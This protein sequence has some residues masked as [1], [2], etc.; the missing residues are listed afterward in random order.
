[1]ALRVANAPCSW[2]ALEFDWAGP[3]PDFARVLD[4]ISAAGYVGTELGDWGF[5]PT[6]P[7]AL[8]RE[9][10]G[11]HLSLIG[12]F[13]PVRLTVDQAHDSGVTSAVRVATL[14]AAAGDAPFVVL[15]DDTARDPVRT[16]RAGRVRP[17]DGLDEKG[18]DTLARGANRIAR[19]VKKETGLRTVFHHHC[20][21]FVETPGE[22]D[23]LMS[24]TD[25]ALVG[26]CLDTG[27]CAF[28]GGKP[29]S[30]A[31]RWKDRVWHVHLKDCE[32]ALRTQS[33]IEGWDY[34]ESVRRG[35]FCELG[36]GEVDF[37]AVLAR[38][39]SMNYSGWLVV[40]QDVLP[41]MGTP[42][43]SAARNRRY[44]RSLGV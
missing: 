36:R 22:I 34:A 16:R 32:P 17:E 27:H 28:G 15:S 43:E 35:V 5:L 1:L 24:R 8:L 21:T 42:A 10:S 6:E 4:E 38:L 18:W 26:L 29:A 7:V 37:R 12:A 30:V 2:G 23:E 11:R 13:V 33:T 9:L 31:E 44:L 14:L 39:E 40:E 25:P 41:S 19:E 3:A 20:A